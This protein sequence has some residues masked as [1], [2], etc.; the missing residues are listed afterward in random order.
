MTTSRRS[1]AADDDANALLAA[2]IATPLEPPA[3]YRPVTLRSAQA[4][5]RHALRG[6]L[7]RT[8]VD[9]LLTFAE[10][11]LA[12]AALL[13][14][15]HWLLDGPVRDGLVARGLLV[16]EPTYITLA[17][18]PALARLA[19]PTAAVLP[20]A[21]P[22]AALPIL[23]GHVLQ[24]L[25]SDPA[26]ALIEIPAPPAV[27]VIPVRIIAPA[28]GLDS[29]IKPTFVVDGAWEVA[30]Y[31]VGYLAGTGEPGA[32]GNTALAGHA[33]IRG[34][35]FAGIGA[36]NPGDAIFID[37]DGQRFQYVVREQLVVWPD[38]VAVLEPTPTPTLTM[39]T[40]TNWDT[41]RLI[42]VADYVGA[43][44]VPGA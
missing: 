43:E 36:L 44:P 37:A 32:P 42:V 11:G 27:P 33:G 28:I 5:R 24:E 19:V 41:Q 6:Y 23:A 34:A 30:D 7:Q 22:R 17:A 2:L 40:C 16:S 12:V 18:P 3:V 9:R 8:W 38:N 10:R 20:T 26:R 1:S 25:P 35:V 39:L 31:A 29:P 21:M 15:G 14:F 4:Q 13:L